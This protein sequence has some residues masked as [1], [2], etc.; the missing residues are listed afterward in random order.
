[1]DHR[2]RKQS[3]SITR[4]TVQAVKGHLWRGVKVLGLY[5][6][7]RGL[8]VTLTL[9][10][11]GLYVLGAARYLSATPPEAFPLPITPPPKGMLFPDINIAA[12][13]RTTDTFFRELPYVGPLWGYLPVF[14]HRQPLTYFWGL[15]I[16]LSLAGGHLLRRKV[17]DAPTPTVVT[18]V[19]GSVN[20]LNTGPGTIA[21][22][23]VESIAA[24]LIRISSPDGACVAPAIAHVTKAVAEAPTPDEAQR[25]YRFEL[26]AEL[27][28]QAALPAAERSPTI[29]RMTVSA[30]DAALS[31]T[32][33][34][35]DIW[36]AWG[37]TIKA[38][39]GISD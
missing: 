18:T 22:R 23:H 28:R 20:V 9:L 36:S 12:L 2:V 24:T 30:L 39:F 19:L 38:F 27:A 3:E 16:P 26:L 4:G 7:W 37:P 17:K 13:Q 11:L 8:G 31:R 6:L 33:N 35:A 10:V 14:D 21:F 29:G 25:T 1:M 15:L 32:A 5:S 34:L